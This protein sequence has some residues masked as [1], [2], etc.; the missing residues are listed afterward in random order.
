MKRV[1]RTFWT[2]A[3][4]ATVA[5]GFLSKGVTAEPGAGAAIT[6]ALSATVLVIA[7]TLAARILMTVDRRS[8]R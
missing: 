6:V 2:L 7:L 8:E 1:R 4:V 3:I 5:I